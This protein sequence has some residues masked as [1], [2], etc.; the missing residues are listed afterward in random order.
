MS[1]GT[2]GTIAGVSKRLKEK[3]ES[4]TDSFFIIVIRYK[5]Y[6]G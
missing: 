2:G 1:A 4:L 6:F 3:R 5:N